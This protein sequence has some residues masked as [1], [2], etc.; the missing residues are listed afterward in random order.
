[1]QYKQKV[2]ERRQTFVALSK[3]YNSRHQLQ[4]IDR[5]TS[6]VRPSVTW[7][8]HSHGSGRSCLL[9]EYVQREIVIENCF[10]LLRS[11][12]RSHPSHP[13]SRFYWRS[14]NLNQFSQRKIMLCVSI[15]QSNVVIPNNY[16]VDGIFAVMNITMFL[17]RVG[18]IYASRYVS[19]Y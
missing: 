2:T 3:A 7:L 9:S 17:I 10:W 8:G 4:A 6:F 14:P 1:M 15:I 12:L 16:Y 19:T 5:P 11:L 18:N 13:R